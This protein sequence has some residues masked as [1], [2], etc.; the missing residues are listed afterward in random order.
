MSGTGEASRSGPSGSGRSSSSGTNPRSISRRRVR[1]T[2]A[3]APTAP[4]ATIPRRGQ[5]FPLRRR[6]P[7]CLIRVSRLSMEGILL[8]LGLHRGEE[9]EGTATEL[10][11]GIDEEEEAGAVEDDRRAG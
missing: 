4:A 1:S 8:P 3:A 5:S 2:T 10:L 6:L 9:P 11:H 7:P